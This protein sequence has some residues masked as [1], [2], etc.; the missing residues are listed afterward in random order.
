MLRCSPPPLSQPRPPPLGSFLCFGYTSGI[1]KCVHEDAQRD[2]EGREKAGELE[3]VCRLGDGRGFPGSDACSKSAHF[4]GEEASI[5]C[6]RWL[7]LIGIEPKVVSPLASTRCLSS[8]LEND[9]DMNMTDSALEVLAIRV[10]FVLFGLSR[11]CGLILTV[12]LS[13]SYHRRWSD[14]RLSY[15]A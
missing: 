8:K 5:V 13:W 15:S 11:Y 14:L 9:V 12:L 2:E 6:F 3:T 10:A 1:S 4:R 7:L